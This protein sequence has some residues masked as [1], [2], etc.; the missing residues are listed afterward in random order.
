MPE[1]MPATT[2][3][4]I[5]IAFALHDPSG[6]YAQHVG[7][8][9]C[10]VC[11]NT[12]WP[13]VAHILHDNTLTQENAEKLA[14]TAYQFHKEVYFYNLQG[15]LEQLPLAQHESV[16]FL[17]PAS[18]S[19]LF[20]P[21]ILPEI[22][23][24]IYLDGDTITDLDIAELWAQNLAGMPLGA[25]PDLGVVRARFIV[26]QDPTFDTWATMALPIWEAMGIPLEKYF[27]AG[28]LVLDLA[29]LRETPLFHEALNL[30]ASYAHFPCLDQDALN[31]IFANMYKALP[32]RYN[33]LM[34]FSPLAAAPAI[35]HYNSQKPWDAYPVARQERYVF[36]HGQT[37]WGK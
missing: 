30:L 29:M 17:S 33:V 6:T 8:S 26:P 28:V 24:V 9:L 5:H 27:N 19:R 15:V 37:P 2:A 18:V 13:L 36:Y 7:A 22:S 31:A 35:W 16:S 1:T 23:R 34:A 21:D 4:T 12:N 3:D 14:Q 25:V 10:S 11:A 32:F 20:L